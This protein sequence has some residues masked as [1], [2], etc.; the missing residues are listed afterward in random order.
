MTREEIINTFGELDTILKGMKI[1]EHRKNNPH[2]LEK[3]LGTFNK[4]NAN[5]NTAMQVIQKLL[6]AGARSEPKQ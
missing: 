1:P 2:W 3:N 6:A 4:D 5:Y